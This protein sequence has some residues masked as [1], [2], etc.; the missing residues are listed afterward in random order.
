MPGFWSALLKNF[1]G[2]ADKVAASGVAAAPTKSA[3]QQNLD[4]FLA[5]P[6]VLSGWPRGYELKKLVRGRDQWTAHYGKVG[7]INSIASA[8]IKINTRTFSVNGSQVSVNGR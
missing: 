2:S 6:P 1:A 4:D 3:Y 8:N 7:Q 5:V